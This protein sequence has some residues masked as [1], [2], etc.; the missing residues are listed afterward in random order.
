MSKLL[1]FTSSQENELKKYLADNNCM[2]VNDELDCKLTNEQRSNTST[3]SNNNGNN[4]SSSNNNK[5]NKPDKKRKGFSDNIHQQ[6]KHKTEKK[7]RKVETQNGG[8]LTE[9]AKPRPHK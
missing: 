4:N 7:K 8:M 3:N 1:G 6:Q 2:L 5:V 9:R